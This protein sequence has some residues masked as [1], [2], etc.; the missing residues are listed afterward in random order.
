MNNYGLIELKSN[1]LRE[2]DWRLGEK[3]DSRNV[4]LQEDRNFQ[5]FL[6]VFESQKREYE[7]SACVTFSAL[8]CIETYINRVYRA[9]FNFSDR[10]TAVMSG[11]IPA[12]GNYLHK[13]AESIRSEENG[14]VFERDYQYNSKTLEEYYE[15]IPQKIQEGARDIYS[16]FAIQWRWVDSVISSPDKLWDALQYGPVQVT[17]FAWVESPDGL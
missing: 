5:P 8:N 2:Q 15:P 1:D 17:G 10:Y 9:E 6:P 3:N 13:V 4:V 16:E 12:V 14:L 7:T 11:T